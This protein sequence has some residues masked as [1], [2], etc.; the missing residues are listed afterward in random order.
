MK[1]PARTFIEALVVGAVALGA[2]LVAN[3]LNPDGLSLTRD[4]FRTASPALV[5]PPAPP[6]MAAVVPRAAP[7]TPSADPEA[8]TAPATSGASG[9]TGASGSSRARGPAGAA[10]GAQAAA[11]AAVSERLRQRG[12]QVVTHDEARAL[13]EDPAYAAGAYVFVDAR[14][15]DAYRAGHVPGAVQF[16]RYH[17]DRHIESVQAACAG[18]LKVIVYCIGVNCEDSEMA[19]QDLPAFGIDPRAVYVYVGGWTA[20]S[21]AGLPVETGARGGGDG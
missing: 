7:D 3:T 8:A 12:L 13:F 14:G 20:W 5:A 2:G 21:A 9:A 6:G 16:D 17:L 1:E 4:H 10:D 18:A 15:D 19:A 11:D